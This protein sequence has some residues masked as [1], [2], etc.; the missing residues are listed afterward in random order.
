M[1]IIG[2][3]PSGVFL[4][5]LQ[6]FNGRSARIFRR[7]LVKKCALLMAYQEEEY[8]RMEENDNGIIGGRRE[9]VTTYMQ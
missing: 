9:I 3:T 1:T 7:R 2:H 4:L 6:C 5:S 8:S